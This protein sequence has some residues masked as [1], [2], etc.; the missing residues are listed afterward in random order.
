VCKEWQDIPKA[1]EIDEET[2]EIAL[3]E[4]WVATYLGNRCFK[5]SDKL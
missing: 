5:I 2:G 4:S 1:V 3:R